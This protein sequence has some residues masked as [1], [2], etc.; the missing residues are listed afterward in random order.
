MN[1]L[2]IFQII[3]DCLTKIEGDNYKG[4][5]PADF[6]ATKLKLLKRMPHG[7]KRIA[8]LINT[9]SPINFRKLL[10]IEKKTNT[11]AMIILG[12]VYLLQ[13]KITKDYK[14]L[15][16]ID[17]IVD[18]LIQNAVVIDETFG[19]NRV[20][21]YQSNIGLHSSYSTLTFINAIAGELFYD[22]YLQSSKN[23]YLESL[24]KICNHLVYK[25]NRISDSKG[26]CL[27]YRNNGNDAILNASILAGKILN[28]AAKIFDNDEYLYL[29][30]EILENTLAKQNKDG[31]WYYSHINGH[32]YKKQIDFHQ[33]Y[34]LDGIRGYENINQNSLLKERDLR[35]KKGLIFYVDKM[36]DNKMY[37]YWRY[38]IKYPI[39]IH[40]LSH[41]IYFFLKY[42]EDI[43]FYYNGYEDRLNKL[44]SLVINVFYDNKNNYFYYQNYFGIKIKHNFLR[45]NNVWTLLALT[46]YLLVDENTLLNKW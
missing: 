31:S 19:F 28:K 21:E 20:I 8:T 24:Q 5:D 33:A 9:Y 3:N 41:A 13:Y 30:L 27:S 1:K 4:Y 18:W 17:I 39:D 15:K 12:K 34:I 35:Y 44:L 36:F 26:I 22:L 46:Q 32:P 37:P 11:T 6:M 38:P 10:K 2:L 25:T 43:K 45:W 7:F 14:I 40:N 23:K 29:S 42:S 16:K